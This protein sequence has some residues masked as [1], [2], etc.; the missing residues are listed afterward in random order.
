MPANSLLDLYRHPE[1]QPDSGRSFLKAFDLYA[2]GCT[3]LVIILWEGLNDIF[4]RAWEDFEKDV[5]L[6][7]NASESQKAHREWTKLLI[8]KEY[9]SDQ[10][11]IKNILNRVAFS[12]ENSVDKAVKKCFFPT[13]NKLE[14]DEKDENVLEI[15]VNVQISILEL[16]ESLKNI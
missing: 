14:D 11:K 5:S 2:L 9:L 16:L 6:P 15:S 13:Q 10:T 7:I 12:A 1:A 3:L 4:R 8:E